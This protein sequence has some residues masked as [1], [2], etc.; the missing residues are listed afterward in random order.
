MN[1]TA[2]IWRRNAKK[3]MGKT[4]I[5][6]P[7]QESNRRIS[8][9]GVQIFCTL[10]ARWSKWMVYSTCEL[11]RMWNNCFFLSL[12]FQSVL[13]FIIHFFESDSKNLS[14][15]ES[16]KDLL[17]CHLSFDIDNEQNPW[18][19]FTFSPI[20]YWAITLKRTEMFEIW[21]HM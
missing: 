8:I 5:D 10:R 7:G 6:Y 2:N 11:C 13:C 3:E 19:K 9:T 1:N 18:I 21:W 4:G 16:M 17:I 14:L 20:G 15:I 12:T